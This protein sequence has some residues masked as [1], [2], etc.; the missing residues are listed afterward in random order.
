MT[1]LASSIGGSFVYALVLVHH[2]VDWVQCT[3]MSSED[4]GNSRAVSCPH[5]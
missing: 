5:H 3:D 4:D 1:N 2:R